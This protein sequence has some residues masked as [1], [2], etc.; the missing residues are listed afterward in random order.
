MIL[1]HLTEMVLL[2]SLVMQFSGALGKQ[3]L[4]VFVES[5]WVHNISMKSIGTPDH[6]QIFKLF[7]LD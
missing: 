4:A 6:I 2:K 3:C 5:N 1:M 7:P